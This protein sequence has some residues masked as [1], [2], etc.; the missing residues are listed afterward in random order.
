MASSLRKINIMSSNYKGC[1]FHVNKSLGTSSWYFLHEQQN[2]T[3]VREFLLPTKKRAYKTE[4][5]LILNLAIPL[6]M[7]SEE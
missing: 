7:E 5:V 2:K 1:F 6:P 3:C 4:A